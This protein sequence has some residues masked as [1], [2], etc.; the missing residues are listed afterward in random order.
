MSKEIQ[1]NQLQKELEQIKKA[2]LDYLEESV[3]H[4]ESLQAEVK[5]L[6][7]ALTVANTKLA[8]A[9]A[10]RLTY[11][12]KASEAKK[13]NSY[14]TD[15]E[16]RGL[17]SV[18]TTN[19]FI[20]KSNI[21][22]NIDVLKS[23]PRA[24]YGLMLKMVEAITEQTKSETINTPEDQGYICSNTKS[25]SE[26]NASRGFLTKEDVAKSNRDREEKFISEMRK[27]AASYSEDPF[28]TFLN[29]F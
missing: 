3:K 23:N 22:A 13:V 25:A 7:D 20:K 5:S 19:G 29:Q 12:K 26:A 11:V 15:D 21:N 27:T 10:E 16:A 24:F 1:Q 17:I 28:K 8:S 6:K 9:E 4:I 2:S 18:L 14:L